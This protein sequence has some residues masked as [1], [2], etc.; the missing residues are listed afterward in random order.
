MDAPAERSIME[1]LE[2]DPE[3]QAHLAQLRE[4]YTF[5]AMDLIEFAMRLL[6]LGQLYGVLDSM[7]H[8]DIVFASHLDDDIEG[9]MGFAW[10]LE[11][12]V[13]LPVDATGTVSVPDDPPE[14]DT[15]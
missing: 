9:A 2:A 8:P 12:V 1:W 5:P 6:H 13:W 7:D 14:D 4:H 10:A 3:V 15:P 11:E